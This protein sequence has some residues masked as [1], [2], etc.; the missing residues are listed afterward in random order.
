MF[1][2]QSGNDVAR[3]QNLAV[4]G[5]ALHAIP[6]V[7]YAAAGAFADSL[8]LK[9]GPTRVMACHDVSLECWTLDLGDSAWIRSSDLLFRHD[10]TLRCHIDLD[11]ALMVQGGRLRLCVTTSR[12]VEVIFGFACCCKTSHVI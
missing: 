4:T 9:L 3:Q 11:N 2:P 12:K 7:P 10:W 5:H 1:I 6:D 8:V